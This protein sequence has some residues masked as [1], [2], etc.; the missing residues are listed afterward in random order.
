MSTSV[1]QCKSCHE[2]IA[3]RHHSGRI[4]VAR[5][6]QAVLMPGGKAQLTCRCGAPRIVEVRATA[7]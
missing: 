5:T 2:Q 6:V 3:T 1:I 7:A 4:T